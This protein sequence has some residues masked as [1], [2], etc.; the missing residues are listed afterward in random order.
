MATEFYWLNISWE[1]VYSPWTHKSSGR[2]PRIANNKLSW[3]SAITSC[4]CWRLCVV[5][6]QQH[7]RSDAWIWQVLDTVSL[8]KTSRFWGNI[9]KHAHKMKKLFFC[10]LHTVYPSHSLSFWP[11]RHKQKYSY[12]SH[13]SLQGFRVTSLASSAHEALA[14]LVRCQKRR[15]SAADW[16]NIEMI[17]C[18]RPQLLYKAFGSMFCTLETYRAK[19]SVPDKAGQLC[20]FW[21]M[22]RLYFSKTN[23]VL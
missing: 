20:C 8:G 15:G 23:R 1:I 6:T 17:F 18:R 21:A 4:D 19:H 10:F 11:Q 22:K 16:V 9:P 13:V 7:K 12:I 3:H 5:S 2:L 14:I